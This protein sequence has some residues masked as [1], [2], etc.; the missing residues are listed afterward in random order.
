MSEL[1][2][3]GRAAVTAGLEI[4]TGVDAWLTAQLCAGRCTA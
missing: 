2:D 4:V 3:D 1:F